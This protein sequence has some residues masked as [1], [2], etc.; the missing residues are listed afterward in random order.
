MSACCPRAAQERTF[1]RRHLGQEPT[2]GPIIRSLRTARIKNADTTCRKLPLTWSTREPHT[3]LQLA[4]RSAGQRGL[5]E[6]P[7]WLTRE[8]AGEM[9]RIRIG[10]MVSCHAGLL[11]SAVRCVERR[12]WLCR[13]RGGVLRAV[14]GTVSAPR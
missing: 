13:R 4:Y 1:Q 8:F 9:I 2:L 7:I 5:P 10:R 11:R 14:L 3:S 12:A 6:A